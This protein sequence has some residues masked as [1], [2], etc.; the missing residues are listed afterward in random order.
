M[1]RQTIIDQYWQ[2]ERELKMLASKSRMP[3]RRFLRELP[4]QPEQTIS[5]AEPMLRSQV[6]L[7][8]LMRGWELET[9]S[10]VTLLP[11]PGAP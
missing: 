7:L 3:L 2:L 10:N 1:S 5:Q 4:L 9:H 8:H 11:M 6:E